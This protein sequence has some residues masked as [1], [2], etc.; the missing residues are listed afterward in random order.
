M[1]WVAVDARTQGYFDGSGMVV[2][3]CA[4]GWCDYTTGPHHAGSSRANEAMRQ[5]DAA[6]HPVN[7]DDE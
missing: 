5:H 4:F 3:Q 1:S 2:Y 7:G 6:K